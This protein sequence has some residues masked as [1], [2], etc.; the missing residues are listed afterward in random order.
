MEILDQL[1][2]EV[3][4]LIR[5]KAEHAASELEINALKARVRDLEAENKSLADTL[6]LER[7]SNKAVLARV[8]SLLAKL[9]AERE[10]AGFGNA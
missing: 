7:R 6:E 9:R 8:D 10:S 4:Q 3:Q 1:E 5:W 2:H